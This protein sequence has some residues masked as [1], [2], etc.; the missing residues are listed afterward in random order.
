MAGWWREGKKSGVVVRGGSQVFGR[1]LARPGSLASRDGPAGFHVDRGWARRRGRRMR[2]DL[3]G[4]G[5]PDHPERGVAP[6]SGR[7]GR[8]R[9]ALRVRCVTRSLS[10]RRQACLPQVRFHLL[11]TMMLHATWLTEPDVR[12]SRTRLPSGIMRLAHG[13]P[14]RGRFGRGTESFAW[15][16]LPEAVRRHPRCPSPTRRQACSRPDG[17]ETPCPPGWAVD[18]GAGEVPWRVVHAGVSMCSTGGAMI[19]REK[20]VLVRHDLEQSMPKAPIARQVA[21]WREHWM[22]PRERLGRAGRR[23]TVHGN[24]TACGSRPCHQLHPYPSGGWTS[25]GVSRSS[26]TMTSGEPTGNG[27]VPRIRG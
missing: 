26:S 2:A 9:G 11:L 22:C 23:P 21:A 10:R 4:L 6:D 27:G 25:C 17:I 14:V 18:Q 19:G 8:W 15:P 7:V 3:R 20:R 24:V 16:Q 13:A 5:A 1:R 12:I